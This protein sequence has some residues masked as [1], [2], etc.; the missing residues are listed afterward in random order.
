ME[1]EGGELWD[2]ILCVPGL[3]EADSLRTLDK[4]D[5]FSTHQLK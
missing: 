1:H 4:A 2:A 3:L 5:K